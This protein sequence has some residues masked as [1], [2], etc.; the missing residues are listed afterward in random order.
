MVVEWGEKKYMNHT[1]VVCVEATL[2]SVV[3]VLHR[4][5][6]FPVEM[7]AINSDGI[8]FF[9]DRLL[10]ITWVSRFWRKKKINFTPNFLYLL[11]FDVID[12]ES[13][14]YM[15][16]EIYTHFNENL[17]E[18]ITQFCMEYYRLLTFTQTI[19]NYYTWKQSVGETN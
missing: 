13:E 3:V 11:S 17:L 16:C 15:G 5:C 9:P 6:L 1:N 8:I 4:H 18:L 14:S 2:L 19:T 10:F 7:W 12:S